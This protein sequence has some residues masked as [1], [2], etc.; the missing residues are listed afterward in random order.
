MKNTLLFLSL[1]LI[2]IHIYIFYHYFL[3]FQSMA[4]IYFPISG[5]DP[6][7]LLTGHY[8][9]FKIVLNETIPCP[10]ENE[11]L[12]GCIQKIQDQNNLLIGNIRLP[13]SQCQDLNCKP[14]IQLQ[15]IKKEFIIP[16]T[17]FFLTEKAKDISSIPEHSYILLRVDDDGKSYIENLYIYKKETNT[18]ITIHEYIQHKEMKNEQD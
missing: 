8:I 15:C 14:K 17:K 11:I 18:L 1:P 7:S 16:Q 4:F 5:Y 10:I 2:I 9:D 6:R 13:L 12:C 3:F